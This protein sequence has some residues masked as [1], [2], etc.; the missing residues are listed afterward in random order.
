MESFRKKCTVLREIG[1]FYGI[2]EVKS[3]F[4]QKRK[5]AEWVLRPDDGLFLCVFEVIFW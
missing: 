2:F 3:G 1:W 5:A 4:R